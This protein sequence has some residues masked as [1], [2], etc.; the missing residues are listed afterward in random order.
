MLR[1]C[2]RKYHNSFAI[3]KLKLQ[4]P[5][6]P[7]IMESARHNQVDY[8]VSPLLNEPKVQSSFEVTTLDG[9]HLATSA[10]E[11]RLWWLTL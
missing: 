3:S 8:G 1:N 7:S 9:V 4:S 6:F 2:E 5:S 11:R 10:K